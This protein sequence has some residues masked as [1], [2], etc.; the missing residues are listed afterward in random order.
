MMR[1]VLIL[2]GLCAGPALAQTAPQEDVEAMTRAILDVECLV[3]A[4]NGD[5]VKLASGLDEEETM[6]VIAALYSDGLVALQA[7]GSMVLS[8]EDCAP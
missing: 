7:D 1:S 4:D 6:A 2:C 3:T 5:A 8:H